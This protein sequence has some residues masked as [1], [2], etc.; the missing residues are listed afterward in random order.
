LP[1]QYKSMI[2]IGVIGLKKSGFNGNKIIKKIPEFQLTGIFDPDFANAKRL[3]SQLNIPFYESPADL[4]AQCNAIYFSLPADKYVNILIQVLKSSK[5]LLIKTPLSIT[6]E[7]ANELV[8]LTREANVVVQIGNTERLNPAF[9]A[10]EKYIKSPMFV[11]IQ[12]YCKPEKCKSEKEAIFDLMFRDIDIVTSINRY[13]IKKVNAIG[14]SIGGNK[15]DI[16]N[17]R[18][19]FNNGAVATLMINSVSLSNILKVKLYQKGEYITIDLIRKQAT[20]VK[21]K[22]TCEKTSYSGESEFLQVFSFDRPKIISINQ[23]IEELTLFRDSIQNKTKSFAGIEEGFLT[24]SIASQIVDKINVY[25]K[26]FS[27]KT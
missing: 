14:V 22:D 16:I 20:I 4:I 24:L 6:L 27:L 1:Q 2:K 7:S 8:K 13:N 11:D 25:Q 3:S 18:L 10:S 15:T 5:H 26:P 12:R 23:D 17:S 19:E 21:F 9:K